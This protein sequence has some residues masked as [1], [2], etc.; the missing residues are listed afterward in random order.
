MIAQH[1]KNCVDLDASVP[2]HLVL[3]LVAVSG[4]GFL[5]DGFHNLVREKRK[6]R[7]VRFEEATEG[8]GKKSGMDTE[9]WPHQYGSAPLMDIWETWCRHL[10][11]P[12]N[13]VYS[14]ARIG[15]LPCAFKTCGPT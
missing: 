1:V 12:F 2:Y 14:L 7:P 8:P 6:I 9:L 11:D 4:S 5:A 10:R 3:R 13:T 15:P